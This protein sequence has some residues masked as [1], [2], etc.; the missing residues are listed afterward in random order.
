MARL[1]PFVEREAMWAAG[2]ASL[3]AIS[4]GATLPAAVLLA[5]R[6]IRR[7]DRG[8]GDGS[9]PAVA[10]LALALAM[11]GFWFAVPLIYAIA[12]TATIADDPWR[13]LAFAAGLVGLS[14]V[15]IALATY[16]LRCHPERWVARRLAMSG[17]VTVV[18]AGG[19]Q[20]A[21]AIS[22]SVGLLPTCGALTA[23]NAD[24]VGSMP[25]S[26]LLPAATM[27]TFFFFLSVAASGARRRVRAAR[28]WRRDLPLRP[29]LERRR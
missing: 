15:V 13:V 22:G 6:T 5:I 21:V 26:V 29:D 28:A 2:L 19:L 3:S 10:A 24:C 25:W 7:K 8:H 9:E 20:T 4:F 16:L 12:R 23:T 18:L 27:G 1:R 11:L 14:C 17:L